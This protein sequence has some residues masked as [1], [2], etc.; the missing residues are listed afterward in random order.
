MRAQNLRIGILVLIAP[1][2]SLPIFAAGFSKGLIGDSYRQRRNAAP[3]SS[4]RPILGVHGLDVRRPPHGQGQEVALFD[5]ESDRFNVQYG[6]LSGS[7]Q[8]GVLDHPGPGTVVE[9]G[10]AI[11]RNCHIPSQSTTAHS[12]ST[13]RKPAHGLAL[14][15]PGDEHGGEENKVCEH[16]HSQ[17]VGRLHS[18]Q[19]RGSHGLNRAVN[20][21]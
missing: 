18:D 16:L 9:E 19:L 13:A 3:D 2:V 5:V 1:E 21:K 12:E 6:Q 8:P 10:S 15:L 14:R 17:I 11:N 7:C 20:V 4:R